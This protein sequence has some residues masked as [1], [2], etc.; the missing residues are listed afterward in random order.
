[1]KSSTT[2]PSFG[3]ICLRIAPSPEM[4]RMLLTHEPELRTVDDYLRVTRHARAVVDRVFWELP[5]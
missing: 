3:R 5:D 1:M 2:S 4:C